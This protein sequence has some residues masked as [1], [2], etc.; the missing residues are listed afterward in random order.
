LDEELIA[1]HRLCEK[2]SDEAVQDRRTVP[3][4]WIAAPAKRA[5]RDDDPTLCIGYS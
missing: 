3:R 2:Q 4:A 5:A 1:P